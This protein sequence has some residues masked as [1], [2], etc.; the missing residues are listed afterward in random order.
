[1]VAVDG[2]GELIK[3]NREDVF[4]AEDESCEGDARCSL[5]WGSMLSDDVLPSSGGNSSDAL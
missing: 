2:V 5:R 1:V 3:E 4:G